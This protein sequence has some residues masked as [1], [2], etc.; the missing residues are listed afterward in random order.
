[1]EGPWKTLPVEANIPRCWCD[2][3]W[4]RR[5]CGWSKSK[6][7][8]WFCARCWTTEG[9][10]GDANA[11]QAMNSICVHCKNK[12]VKVMNI[13]RQQVVADVASFYEIHQRQFARA[14]QTT[15]MSANH[16]RGTMLPGRATGNMVGRKMSAMEQ[17]RMNANVLESAREIRDQLGITA[18]AKSSNDARS[19]SS[20]SSSSSSKHA[21][22]KRKKRSKSSSSSSG[23]VAAVAVQSA[24]S[25]SAESDEA[26][27]AKSEVLGKLQELTKV[28]PKEQRQKAF[29]ALLRAW[30]PDK[31][32]EKVE[33]ATHVFQFLQKGKQLLD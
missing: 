1:M 2:P 22:K 29:R 21:K 32:P 20:S 31:N 33:V 23:S 30:H 28:H 7:G 18:K 9:G 3:T 15:A 5:A 24:G 13:Q 27:K 16:I 8:W 11:Q 25:E 4:F 26:A 6:K 17:V 10:L 19:S 14:Q 12:V